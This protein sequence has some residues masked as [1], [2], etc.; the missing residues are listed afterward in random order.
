ML[1]VL[2]Q[3]VLD[4]GDP[5]EALKACGV[6]DLTRQP[7]LAKL[8][9]LGQDAAFAG[10]G[11]EH[12]HAG[13]RRTLAAMLA[14]SGQVNCAMFLCP[15]RPRSA[16]EVAVRLGFAPITTLAFLLTAQ[17]SGRLNAALINQHV[18]VAGNEA[19]A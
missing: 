9:T 13:I 18:W 2:N 6:G 3:E 17:D 5:C 16:R 15:P 1:F 19:A 8:V 4:L 11:M 7:S 10:G 12:A 14:M